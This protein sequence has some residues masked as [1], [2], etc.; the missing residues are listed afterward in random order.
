MLL[1]LLLLMM[2]S[3]ALQP[4]T[5]SGFSTIVAVTPG[6]MSADGDAAAALAAA[7]AAVEGLLRPLDSLLVID[8]IPILTE[9][10]C[11]CCFWMLAW[12]SAAAACATAA[13]LSLLSL[14]RLS[15]GVGWLLL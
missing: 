8:I 14:A 3:V 1:S 2:S 4:V 6:C 12:L 9:P 7:A 11:W 15:G 13:R 10:C 5:N